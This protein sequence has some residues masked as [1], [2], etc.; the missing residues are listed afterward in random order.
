MVILIWVKSDLCKGSQNV[1]HLSW[2]VPVFFPKEHLHSFNVQNEGLQLFVIIF[3]NMYLHWPF[4][5]SSMV[6]NIILLCLTKLHAVFL[7]SLPIAAY[8]SGLL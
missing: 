8:A 2:G 4:L 7:Q 6:T 3:S 5:W 1:T